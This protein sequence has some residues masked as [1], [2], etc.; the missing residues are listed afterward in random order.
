MKLIL[1]KKEVEIEIDD[2]KL[3]GITK[4]KLKE[5]DDEIIV[6]CEDDGYFANVFSSLEGGYSIYWYEI[7]YLETFRFGNGNTEIEDVD[8][9]HCS[10]SIIDALLWAYC[11]E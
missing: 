11:Q 7:K 6:I 10:G 1:G 8:G 5:Y 9:A 2:N 4:N 3:I